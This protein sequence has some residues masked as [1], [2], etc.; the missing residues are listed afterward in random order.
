L[1]LRLQPLFQAL[2]ELQAA[3]SGEAG[4]QLT[5]AELL[6]SYAGFVLGNYPVPLTAGDYALTFQPCTLTI[7]PANQTIPWSQPVPILD[8]TQLDAALAVVGLMVWVA[9]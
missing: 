9:R 7:T 3:A 2:E 6:A 5:G 1:T 8:G 4:G